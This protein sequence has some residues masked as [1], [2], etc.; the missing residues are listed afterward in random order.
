MTKEKV[1]E[2]RGALHQ[3]MTII[4]FPLLLLLVGDMYRDFKRVR[5]NDIKQEVMIMHNEK[6]I[7]ALK[8]SMERI[9]NYVW[10]GV[11]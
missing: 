11:K 3:W 1:S 8:S 4:G 6:D 10:R 5:E 7:D 2:I 9:G